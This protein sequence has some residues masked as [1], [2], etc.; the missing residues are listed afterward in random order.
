MNTNSS[1]KIKGNINSKNLKRSF[2]V[3]TNFTTY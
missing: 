2:M 1:A 3:V